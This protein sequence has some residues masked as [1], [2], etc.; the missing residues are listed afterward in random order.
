LIDLI[1]LFLGEFLLAF[2]GLALCFF[3]QA[4]DVTVSAAS[5]PTITYPIAKIMVAID[6]QWIKEK[7]DKK[8]TQK[9]TKI[10]QCPLNDISKNID[11]FY[12]HYQKSP[13]A[14]IS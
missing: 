11:K 13:I 8:N 14:N 10:F 5:R 3:A 1:S 9:G 7:Y 12:T 6:Y 2:A 4:G